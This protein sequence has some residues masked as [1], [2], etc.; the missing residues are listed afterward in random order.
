MIKTRP[1]KKKRVKI[2]I[3]PK[4]SIQKGIKNNGEIAVMKIANIAL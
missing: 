2:S 3:S 4:V 1:H